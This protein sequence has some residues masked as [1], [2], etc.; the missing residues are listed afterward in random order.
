M[1]I[2]WDFLYQLVCAN[3]HQRF[4]D[5]VLLQKHQDNRLPI[6][7]P[8]RSTTNTEQNYCPIEL[9]TLS[10][11]FACKKFHQFIYGQKCIIDNH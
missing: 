2:A 4:D 6:A 11:V 1:S 10:V 9:E 3:I 8:S 7:Y 5:Y